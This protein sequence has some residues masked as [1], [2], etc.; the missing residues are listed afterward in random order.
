MHSSEY[1][2]YHLFSRMTTINIIDKK[3]MALVVSSEKKGQSSS[4]KI[5]KILHYNLFSLDPWRGFSFQ[6]LHSLYAL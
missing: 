1:A 4:S 3:L 5:A 6:Y 2:M